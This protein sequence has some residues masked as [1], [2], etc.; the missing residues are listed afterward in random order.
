MGQW[1]LGVQVMSGKGGPE[2]AAGVNRNAGL[3]GS[4]HRTRTSQTS[5]QHSSVP[6]LCGRVLGTPCWQDFGVTGERAQEHHAAPCWL[7]W[8][9]HMPA[10]GNRGRTRHGRDGMVTEDFLSLSELCTLP[11]WFFFPLWG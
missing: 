6:T 2:A 5:S 7:R 9:L 3:R 11:G 10:Q 4:L 1:E 8:V